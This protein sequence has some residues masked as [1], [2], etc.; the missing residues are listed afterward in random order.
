MLYSIKITCQWVLYLNKK[1]GTSKIF[2]IKSNKFIPLN[3]KFDIQTINICKYKKHKR[4]GINHPF[5][6]Y[7]DKYTNFILVTK[8]N[9]NDL[10][11]DDNHSLKVLILLSLQELILRKNN[12]ET[13]GH[14]KRHVHALYYTFFVFYKLVKL[15]KFR[16][17]W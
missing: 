3:S 2:N 8:E 9:V 11:L 14:D 4:L 7:K 6:I 5:H 13:F 17:I 10:N 12:L 1:Y 16:N 15:A